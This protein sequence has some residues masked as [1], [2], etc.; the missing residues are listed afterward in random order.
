[1]AT[2]NPARVA[3]VGGRQRGLAAGDRADFVLFRWNADASKITILE[4]IVGGESVFHNA[5]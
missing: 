5:T 1:M 2:R 4:T 3:R